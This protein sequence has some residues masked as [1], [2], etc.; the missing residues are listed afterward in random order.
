MRSIGVFILFPLS[1][2]FFISIT[3]GTG[4]ESSGMFWKFAAEAS[5]VF[6]NEASGDRF[7]KLVEEGKND[8][9]ARR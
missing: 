3:K 5:L 6:T 7:L 2:V 8:H 9:A 4:N 1:F